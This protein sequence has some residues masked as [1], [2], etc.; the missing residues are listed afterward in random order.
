M[1]I[2][3]KNKEIS[4]FEEANSK[5]RIKIQIL[6]KTVEELKNTAKETR[7]DGKNQSGRMTNI[8]KK[9]LA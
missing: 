4:G 7:D 3:R 1:M 2:E 6:Q 5:N 9:Q 8:L